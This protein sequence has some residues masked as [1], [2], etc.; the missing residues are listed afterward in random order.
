MLSRPRCATIV[1]IALG[2]FLAFCDRAEALTPQP[3]ALVAIDDP[4]ALPEAP[5]SG[6]LYDAP[7]PAATTRLMLFESLQ[8]TKPHETPPS[9]RYVFVL[10]KNT[11]ARPVDATV[12]GNVAG[13]ND[14]PT[15]VGEAATGCFLVNRVKAQTVTHHLLAGQSLTL[16]GIKLTGSGS[17][18]SAII[19]VGTD[20]PLD[21]R[22]TALASDSPSPSPVGLQPFDEVKPWR[23][24]LFNLGSVS[25][26]AVTVDAVASRQTNPSLGGQPISVLGDDCHPLPSINDG[27][28]K[29]HTAAPHS[30]TCFATLNADGYYDLHGD[31]GVERT[32]T[33]TLVNTGHLPYSI[34]LYVR[35][36]G[37]DLWGSFLVDDQI[38][39]VANAKFVEDPHSYNGVYQIY[40]WTINPG[41]QRRVIITTMGQGEAAYPAWIYISPSDAF[42]VAPRPGD[43]L[44]GPARSV[45][46]CPSI[47]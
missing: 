2:V 19:D 24:G 5:A 7:L 41:E 42:P 20:R 14:Q 18:T 15:T 4:E 12:L 29:P 10:L 39:Q 6:L 11:S 46:K 25:P 1:L 44:S 32:I 40:Y 45:T 31:Y 8:S 23:A 28:A 30:Y 13:P 17:T 3:T 43:A 26:I 27:R 34:S 47:R 9:P 35:P 21:L 38:V 22:L 37:G 16:V 33:A 36:R